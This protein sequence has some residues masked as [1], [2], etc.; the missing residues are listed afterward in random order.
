MFDVVQRLSYLN[1]IMFRN[2]DL[3]PLSGKIGETSV[4]GVR[5]KQQKTVLSNIFVY[6]LLPTD[7]YL[8]HVYGSYNFLFCPVKTDRPLTGLSKQD[9]F[10][11][12]SC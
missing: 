5:K 11:F 7:S 4:K 3:L 8:R 10:F 1:Y 9:T 2:V 12:Y 6:V